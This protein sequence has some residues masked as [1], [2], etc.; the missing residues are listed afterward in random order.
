MDAPPPRT[1]RAARKGDPFDLDDAPAYLAWREEKLARAP[2]RLDDLVVEV[3]DLEHPTAAERKALLQRVRHANMVIYHCALTEHRTAVLRFAENFGLFSLDRN[4]AADDDG[5]SAIRVHEKPQPGE[6]IPYTDRAIRWHTDGYYNPPERRIGAF[7]LHCVRPATEGGVNTLL[8]PDLLYLR[9]RDADP[10]ALAALMHPRAM[11]I[12]A[13]VEEGVELRPE[14]GGPVFTVLRGGPRPALH[15]RYTARTRSIRWR[16][17]AATR[18]AVQLLESLLTD[19]VDGA[20]EHRL[21]PG[22]GLLC[23]NVLHSRSGFRDGPGPGRLLY[24]ARF[25]ERIAGS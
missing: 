7:L 10:D 9:L 6:F 3:R 18:R 12:P 24:R 15:L 25:H 14:Q 23:N 2:A 1:S 13:H 11:T 5:L 17:D 16:D 19:P 4:P 8:D 20:L 22:Q 21:E